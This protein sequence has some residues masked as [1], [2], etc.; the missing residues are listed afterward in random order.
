MRTSN[1]IAV[2]ALCLC[3]GPLSTAAFAQQRLGMTPSH[4]YGLWDSINKAVL[5]LQMVRDGNDKPAKQLLDMKPKS[6]ENAKAADALK[7]VAAF[8]K[9]IDVLRRRADLPPTRIYKWNPNE[10]ITP[11]IVFLNSGFALDALMEWMISE[12]NRDFLIS[13]F[14]NNEAFTG[15]TP[16]DVASLA[17]LAT[18]RFV[19]ILNNG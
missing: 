19:W 8:R 16:G 13:P 7:Y 3:F 1:A 6:F 14:Y 12:T 5:A 4:V 17:E 15:K 2:F 9:Q 10:E 11:S 18:R